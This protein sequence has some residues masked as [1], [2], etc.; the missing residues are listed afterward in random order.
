VLRRKNAKGGT[1]K[2]HRDGHRKGELNRKLLGK[3]PRPPGRNKGKWKCNKIFENKRE[4]CHEKKK[5]WGRV[6][7]P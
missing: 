3:S 1:G 2:S 4:K 7:K 5:S 6:V